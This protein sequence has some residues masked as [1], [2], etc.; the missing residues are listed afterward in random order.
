MQGIVILAVPSIRR[1]DNRKRTSKAS[2]LKYPRI[3]FAQ[4]VRLMWKGGTG[5]FYGGKISDYLY[6]RRYATQLQSN[7][8]GET[9]SSSWGKVL[10]MQLNGIKLIAVSEVTFQFL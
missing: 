2:L 10:S 5:D 1:N 7:D 9:I 6:Y 4:C 3:Q 8:A